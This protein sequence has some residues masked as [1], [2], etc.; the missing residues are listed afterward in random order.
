MRCGVGVLQMLPIDCVRVSCSVGRFRGVYCGLC[1]VT[2]EGAG[3]GA[4]RRRMPCCRWRSVLGG[5]PR[6]RP[7]TS[8]LFRPVLPRRLW[9]DVGWV[10][11]L[12][13]VI[14]GVRDVTPH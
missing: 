2:R 6:R 7:P 10:G 4:C 14:S 12:L 11:I 8:C 9:R 1:L 13:D 5:L 3:A